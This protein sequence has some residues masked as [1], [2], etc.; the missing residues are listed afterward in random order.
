MYATMMLGALR[1]ILH[2][3]DMAGIAFI[4]PCSS[5]KF[6][7]GLV[8]PTPT[9]IPTPTPTPDDSNDNPINPVEILVQPTQD[10]MLVYTTTQGANLSV[11][12]AAGTVETPTLL[13]LGQITRTSIL[14]PEQRS[15]IY[16]FRMQ[17]SQNGEEFTS[18]SFP[19]PISITLHYTETQIVGLNENSLQ[20][21]SKQ[22]GGHL[23]ERALCVGVEYVR[24][25]NEDWLLAPICHLTEFALL[26]EPTLPS[27]QVFLPLVRN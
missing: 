4:Y 19:S 7:C 20:L 11:Q 2:D 13:S 24:N 3:N 5:E 25:P 8:T 14:S 18:F 22:A 12:I 23:W 9:P 15:V 1:R 27:Y 26:G 6:P 21:Y 16:A 10:S 17:A